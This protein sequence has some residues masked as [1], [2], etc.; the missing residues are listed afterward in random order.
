MCQGRW[1]FKRQDLPLHGKESILETVNL[2]K[3]QQVREVPGPM[4]HLTDVLLNGHVVELYPEIGSAL[5]CGQE[6]LHFIAGRV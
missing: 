1:T 5:K 3:S 4:G 2:I 6:K